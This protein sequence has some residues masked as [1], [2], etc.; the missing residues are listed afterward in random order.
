VGAGRGDGMATGSALGEVEVG[1]RV[2]CRVPGTYVRCG[3]GTSAGAALGKP[4]GAVLGSAPGAALG[5][6]VGAGLG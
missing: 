1:N 2:V 5:K 3:D 6:P 4:V